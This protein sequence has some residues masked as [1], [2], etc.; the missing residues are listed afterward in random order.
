LSGSFSLN[1]TSKVLTSR[2][3]K[4]PGLRTAIITAPFFSHNSFALKVLGSEEEMETHCLFPAQSSPAQNYK[5]LLNYK[6]LSLGQKP[7]LGED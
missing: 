1:R 4:Q 2:Q 5:K 6:E 7:G 3:R